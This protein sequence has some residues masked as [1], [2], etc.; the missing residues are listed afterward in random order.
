M[1]IVFQ[2]WR[3]IA[4]TSLVVAATLGAGLLY[5]PPTYV[6]EAK[7]LIQTERQASPWGLLLQDEAG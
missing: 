6:A 1:S 2:H 5:L 3:L 4:T 7:L